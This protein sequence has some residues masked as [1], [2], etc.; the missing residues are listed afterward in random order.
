[1]CI[2]AGFRYYILGINF[3]TIKMLL[4]LGRSSIVR[5]HIGYLTHYKMVC[6][7]E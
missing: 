2:Y 1:M 5:V 6:D 4:S 7:E 3:K